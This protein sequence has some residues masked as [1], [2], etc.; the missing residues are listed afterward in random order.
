V[1]HAC[2]DPPFAFSFSLLHAP[3]GHVAIQG[4]QY[5]RLLDEHDLFAGM[6]FYRQHVVEMLRG[7]HLGGAR[8]DLVDRTDEAL[9]AMVEADVDVRIGRYR[10]VLRT[11]PDR[12]GLMSLAGFLVYGKAE[13][14][15]MEQIARGLEYYRTERQHQREIQAAIGKLGAAQRHA[16]QVLLHLN[17]PQIAADLLIML[18]RHLSQEYFAAPWSSA[19]ES[20]LWEAAHGQRNMFQKQGEQARYLSEKCQGW[21]TWD[22][23]ANQPKYVSLSEWEGIY[24]VRLM[25]KSE[26]KQP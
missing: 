22:A 7:D 21:A 17:E 6:Q 5:V 3:G 14:P 11:H 4:E 13:D 18:M 24:G 19:L 20:Q 25:H 2:S 12:A 16:T 9:L 23:V 15:R 26:E 10:E 8:L 1:E